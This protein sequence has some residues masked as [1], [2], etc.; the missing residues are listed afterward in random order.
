GWLEAAGS[1]RGGTMSWSG[2]TETGCGGAGGSWL[3][4]APAGRGLTCRLG[5]TRLTPRTLP[6]VCSISR[7]TAPL[8]PPPRAKTRPAESTVIS[9]S[10]LGGGSSIT[11][12][13]PGAPG[14]PSDWLG[15]AHGLPL[16]IAAA[17]LALGGGPPG[18]AAAAGGMGPAPFGPT[19]GPSRRERHH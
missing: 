16:G 18:P 13:G 17:G 1:R 15:G 8:A 5:K 4:P 6:A 7:A 19:I 10:P 9:M 12:A 2:W 3:A 11:P 14:W